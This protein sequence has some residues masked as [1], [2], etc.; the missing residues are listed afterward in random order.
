VVSLS[1]YILGLAT[2]IS[3]SFLSYDVLNHEI[4]SYEAIVDTS[5]AVTAPRWNIA[6]LS[7]DLGKPEARRP[8]SPIYPATPGKELLRTADPAPR[9][10]AKFEIWKSITKTIRQPLPLV[11]LPRQIYVAREQDRYSQQSTGYAFGPQL[12][13]RASLNFGHDIY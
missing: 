12:R 11:G 5:P 13:S 4:L 10:H 7:A 1:K 6:R 8:L 9:K 3:V 2:L